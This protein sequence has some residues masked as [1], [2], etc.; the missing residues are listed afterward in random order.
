MKKEHIPR[1][2]QKFSNTSAL[3]MFP[4]TKQ[5]EPIQAPR[6]EELMSQS[7]SNKYVYHV[8]FKR[9]KSSTM[10]P[11]ETCAGACEKNV[12]FSCAKTEVLYILCPEIP[13]FA[14][15]GMKSVQIEQEARKGL[16]DNLPSTSCSVHS[17][18]PMMVS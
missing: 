9:L 14:C 8:N 3:Q 6:Q 1:R 4:H 2:E 13:L 12:Q 18:M 16:Y 10:C 15:Q 7:P 11:V 5:A 17:I